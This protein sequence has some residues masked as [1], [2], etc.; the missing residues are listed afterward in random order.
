MPTLKLVENE[1]AMNL[2]TENVYTFAFDDVNYSVNKIELTKMLRAK[3]LNP[4]DVRIVNLPSK[5][6]LRQKTRKKSAKK[7][8]KKYYVKLKD[9]DKIDEKFELTVGQKA[10]KA[11]KVEE[12][13]VE[14]KETKSKK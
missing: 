14:K 10:I 7:R 12:K 8:A 11:E 1:K 6:K 5:V 4:L 13:K 3:G 9:G 2:Q